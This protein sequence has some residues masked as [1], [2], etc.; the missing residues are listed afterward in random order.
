LRKEITRSVR[1][2]GR[3]PRFVEGVAGEAS[4]LKE[5]KLIAVGFEQR[6]LLN[7]AIRKRKLHVIYVRNRHGTG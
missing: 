1:R 6:S 2:G 4:K 7:K 5:L 3:E